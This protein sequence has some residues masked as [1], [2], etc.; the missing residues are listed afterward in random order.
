MT[1]TR[2]RAIMRQ[3]G[4]VRQ[5]DTFFEELTV[6]DTLLYSAMLGLPE[7]ISV[8][9]KM[10]RVDAVL[11]EVGLTGCAHAKVGGIKFKGA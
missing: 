1:M 10:S 9:E 3:Q 11:A 5:E 4:Y 7:T 2:F 6:R 8:D